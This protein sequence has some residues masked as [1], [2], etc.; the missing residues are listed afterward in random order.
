MGDPMFNVN[1]RVGK[2]FGCDT[3]VIPNPN[4]VDFG[5]ASVNPTHQIGSAGVPTNRVGSPTN[6]S[7]WRQQGHNIEESTADRVI[8]TKVNSDYIFK[9]SLKL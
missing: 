4:F 6:S 8:E 9:I 3:I 7:D 5:L 1:S 2:K